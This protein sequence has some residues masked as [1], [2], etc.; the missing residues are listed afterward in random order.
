[1][2][3][4]IF[5]VFLL[6]SSLS[7]F[8]TGNGQET[9]PVLKGSY[10]GQKPPGNEPELFAA[11]IVSTGVHEL[12][13][14]ISPDLNE[15]LFSR[16]GFDWHTAIIKIEKVD[17]IWRKPETFEYSEIMSCNYPFISFDGSKLLFES[18]SPITGNK[19]KGP[20]SNIWISLRKENKWSKPE[21]L[22]SV[23]NS[24]GIESFPSISDNGNIYYSARYEN[25]LGKSDIFIS[26]YVNG[27]YI[28]PE[29]LGE[30][31]NTSFSEFHAF[32]AHDES[33]IIFD[34]NREDGFG[35]NDLFISFRKNDG[36]WTKAINMGNVINSEYSESRP[37]VS[38]DGKYLFF[39][40]NRLI[41]S[42]SE[43]KWEYDN[44][45]KRING[46]GNSLQDIY[47]M[48]SEIIAGLKP[49]ELK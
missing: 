47:W 7:F 19:S 39:C 38:P 5:Y 13:I 20:D 44:F 22:S 42:L 17:G 33:Y 37:Y 25:S 15:I 6:V 18:R 16:A 24:E 26:K 2:K 3:C 31:V 8:C 10:L 4:I 32:I 11:D 29:N 43:N 28:Q 21:K 12:D 40:S 45:M 27:E 36:T 34:S 30:N 41:P 48:N 46:P 14:T 35:R 49:D 9:F 23:I 1:M